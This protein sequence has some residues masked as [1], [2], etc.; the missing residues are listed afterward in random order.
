MGYCYTQS[1][2]LCCDSCGD[3]GNVRKCACP[4]GYCPPMALCPT[5]KVKHAAEMSREAHQARGCERYGLEMQARDAHKRQLLA[6]GKLVRCA[7][8]GVGN[9]R[10]HVLF[11]GVGNAMLGFIVSQATYN[12]IPILEPATPEDFAKF[13]ELEPAGQE[14]NF[15]A[16]A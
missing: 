16:T 9:G 12:A 10:V 5:C 7:A 1:G 14:F 15:S 6:S 8:L 3:S 13:G 11:Q 4:Y 2:N